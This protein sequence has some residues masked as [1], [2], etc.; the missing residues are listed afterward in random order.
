M[1]GKSCDVWKIPQFSTEACIYKNSV[2]LETRAQIAGIEIHSIATSFE[3]NAKIPTDKIQIS[4]TAKIEE[5]SLADYAMPADS[6][7]QPEQMPN[8]NDIMRQVTDAQNEAQ[9]EIDMQNLSDKEITLKEKELMLRE[10][11]LEL[12]AQEMA[13]KNQKTSPNKNTLDK[14]NQAVSTTN[15]V[16][17]TFNGLK[18]IFGR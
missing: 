13:Q 14:M 2:P 15:N 9:D 17:N 11:E 12:K 18:S 1:L 3:E 8:L 10:K 7:I 16:K 4:K 6:H 5:R